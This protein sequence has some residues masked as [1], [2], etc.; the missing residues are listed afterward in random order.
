MVTING[1]EIKLIG[2]M[3]TI[4][5]LILVALELIKLWGENHILEVAGNNP[6]TVV[7]PMRFFSM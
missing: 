4:I 5:S 2:K 7:E 6:L 3:A 1:I